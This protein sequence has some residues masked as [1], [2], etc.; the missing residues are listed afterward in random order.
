[1]RI[2]KA[3]LLLTILPLL[4][5]CITSSAL[6]AAKGQTSRP[7]HDK[8]YHVE[9]AIVSTNQQL[10]VYLEGC[11][12]NSSQRT[13][14]TVSVSLDQIRKANTY[15]FS[16]TDKDT[17]GLLYASRASIHAG[18]LPQESSTDNAVTV[19]LGLPIPIARRVLGRWKVSA[20]S[21]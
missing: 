16:A 11:L 15:V 12:T 14:F 21:C 1:M 4:S 6:D 2:L 7:V 17:Y 13:R 3:I 18:W 8:V 19:P 5:G 20:G 9:R 10:V